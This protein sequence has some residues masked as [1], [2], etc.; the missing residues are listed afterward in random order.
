MA[1]ELEENI[2]EAMENSK[3]TVVSLVRTSNITN[4]P[5]KRS[6]WLAP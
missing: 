6:V 2:F 4:I 3:K 1:K 5:Q